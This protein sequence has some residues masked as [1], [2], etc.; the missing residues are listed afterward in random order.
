[1]KYMCSWVM[2]LC[3]AVPMAWAAPPI[4]YVAPNGNDAWSGTSVVP[5]GNDGP[6][7]T[8]HQAQKALR[9]AKPAEGGT[10]YVREGTYC[11]PEPLR[12][13]ALDSGTA[14]HEVLWQ[15]YHGETVRLVAGGPINNFVPFKDQILQSDLKALGLN[16]VKFEQLFFNSDRQILARWPNLGSDNMPGGGWAFVA[17]AVEN[18]RNTSFC[19]ADD[20]PQH[21]K[22]TEGAQVNIWPNY[23]W[24]QAVASIAKVKTRSKKI[25]L[26]DKLPYT[27]EPGRRYFYQNV[28][29]ELDAPGEWFADAEAGKLYFWPPEPLGS[30]EVIV[31][32]LESA[33]VFDKAHNI[34]FIGFTIEAAREDGIAVNESQDCL[35]AK[36]IIRNTGNFGVTV[37][38]GKRVRIVGNDIHHTGAGGIVLNGGDRKTLQPG[39]HTAVNNHIHHFAEIHATYNTGVNVSGVEQLVSNNLIHDAPHIAILLTGNDHIIEYNEVHHICMQASDNGA[40]YMGRDWTQRG[41]IIRYNKF[42]DI[43]GFGLGTESEGAYHYQSPDKRLGHLPGRLQ[44]RHHDFRK[45]VLP[46]AVVR[47]H[48]WRRPGQYDRKQHLC[49]EYPRHTY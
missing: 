42:H 28:F 20:R 12:L 30:G 24:W 43:Y 5:N 33:V 17:A 25:T 3:A 23:N 19:Y 14:N 4:F 8:L 41:N 31:P 34:S 40:F 2:L 47:C 1:M 22:T 21:W 11:L 26:E 16:K 46:R 37:N 48:D 6:F 10:V 35:I 15:S 44:Q 27:I 36:N 13:E 9:Q 38:G 18:D 29:E 49:G 7:A 45:S 32:V 39:G